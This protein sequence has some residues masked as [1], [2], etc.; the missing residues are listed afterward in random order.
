MPAGVS[1]VELGSGLGLVFKGCDPWN[2]R[3]NPNGE[4]PY[5]GLP[6][7]AGAPMATASLH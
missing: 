3:V 4:G 5:H 2:V 1:G 6:C 7:N